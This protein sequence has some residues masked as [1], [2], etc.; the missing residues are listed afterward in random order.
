MMPANLAS[1]LGLEQSW[2][3]QLQV[4]AGAN[5]IADQQIHV[6]QSNPHEYVEVVSTQK[7]NNEATGNEE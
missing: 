1:R 5:S 6:H 4:P 7:R 2:Q 3:R